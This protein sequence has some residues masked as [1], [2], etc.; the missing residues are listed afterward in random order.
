MASQTISLLADDYATDF[1]NLIGRYRG[2]IISSN[3]PEID[4]SLR[5][6]TARYLS[7][8]RFW[9]EGTF[10]IDFGSTSTAVRRSDLTTQFETGG[11]VTLT[12]GQNSVT[13]EMSDLGDT[14]DP[15]QGNPTTGR[16]ERIALYNALISGAAT[17]VLDDGTT[18]ATT[19]TANAG[20]D[21]TVA[22]GGTT[23]IGGADTVENGSGANSISWS[24]VSGTTV[25]IGTLLSSTTAASPT[26]TAPTITAGGA[27]LT[28]VLRKTVT[29]NGISD[30]DDVTITVTAPAAL[31][32]AVAPT[33]SI[34]SV[35]AGNEGTTVAL[36]A[37]VA[38]GTYDGAITYAWTVEG[39]TLD[40]ATAASPTW[41]RPAVNSDTNYT[42]DLRISVVGTGTNARN[43]TTASRNATQIS[44]TVNNV[45]VVLP[46]ADAPSVTINNVP[47]GDE[48]SATSLGATLG[49]GG[50]YDGAVEYSWAVSGGTLSDNTAA[51]PVWT[52]PAVTSDT[53]V[54]INLTITVRGT[55]TNARSSTSD[56]SVATAEQTTVRNV[57][58]GVTPSW[59]PNTGSTITATTGTAIQDI[60]IPAANGAPEPTYSVDN[61]PFGLSFN[62]GTRT[63]SGT[64]LVATSS[65]A[66][67]I[68]T[69]SVGTTI[70]GSRW[71]LS[72]DITDPDDTQTILLDGNWFDKTTTRLRWQPGTDN[73][74]RPQVDSEF[75][76]TGEDRYV[77]NV[78]LLN[79]PRI[80]FALEEAAT[81]GAVGVDDD[82]SAAFE[83][84]GVITV[85]AEDGTSCSYALSEVTPEDTT[86]P[87]NG[88][89]PAAS[90]VT[91]FV[92][93]YT[94][95][96]NGTF[97]AALRLYLPPETTTTTAPSWT[98]TSGTAFTG[99]VNTALTYDTP[100]LDAGDGTIEYTITGEP[101][102]ITID[103]STG[104]LSGTPTTAG[105]GT[106][107][108]TATNTAGSDSITVAWSIAAADV[109]PTFSSGAT[110]TAGTRIVL[111]FSEALDTAHVPDNGDFSLTIT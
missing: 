43:G 86:E 21:K 15:Y 50:T 109:A 92:N 101:G 65:R 7:G 12:Q 111:T 28:I 76:P 38:G 36:S 31:P 98:A 79:T 5:G 29:N 93:A 110:N 47:A 89:V 17:I 30:P 55:G 48:G 9:S 69:N 73:A 70:T 2:W 4:S 77:H 34:D 103:S 67:V 72:V 80:N 64:P 66:Y 106:A 40:D 41:T 61:L 51:A 62:A 10:T 87:Y 39:G 95:L 19:V 6:D 33:V 96:D 49:S 59:T 35:A 52:R 3:R 94:G 1:N 100:A 78:A 37:S 26:F 75:C 58:T 16:T 107:T 22:S 104:D 25:T 83:E 91:D 99:T 81:G 45:A 108:I 23:T 14:T 71:F 74:A 82:L 90:G 44:A 60:V 105:S 88:T 84:R 85:T 46:A 56:T 24:V 53:N 11:S 20:A 63:I 68:A 54:S 8:V 27:D 13:I 18:P 32:V 97:P 57:A 42:I 102:G